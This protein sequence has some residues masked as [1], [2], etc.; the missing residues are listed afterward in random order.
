M[1]P[2]FSSSVD[3]MMSVEDINFLASLVN[4]LSPEVAVEIGS[5][6]GGSARLLSCFCKRLFCIDHWMHDLSE[7]GL[8]VPGEFAKLNPRD[9]FVQFCKNLEGSLHTEIFPCVGPSET[10]AAVWRVPIDFLFIDGDHSY[11]G[12]KA[13]ILGF[14]PHVRLGGVIA[15]HDYGPWPDGITG[16]LREF[17]GVRKAVD[18]I[19]P[20]ATIHPGT[21]IWYVVKD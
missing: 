3:V 14:S 15:G 6:A 20:N 5:W 13:D 8:S 10:W 2:K 4:K 1:E 7:M 11:E 18:E 12:V 17:I 21:K 9:R 19:F 16:E